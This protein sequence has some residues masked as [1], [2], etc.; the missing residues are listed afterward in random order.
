MEQKERR[1]REA[2]IDALVQINNTLKEILNELRWL[3][4]EDDR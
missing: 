3:V 4:N 2:M 1:E